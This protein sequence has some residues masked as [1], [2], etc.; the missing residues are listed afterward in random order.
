M[1]TVRHG[2]PA[3][4]GHL[5]A[6][7][8]A[9]LAWGCTAPHPLA[10][11]S[12]V[13][14]PA[15]RGT[16]TVEVVSV[17][18]EAGTQARLDGEVGKGHATGKGAATGAAT[19]A[20]AG[21]MVSLQTGPF[22][23][24]LAPILVPA[25]TLMGGAG[26]AVVG[27]AQGIP[28]KEAQAVKALLARDPADLSAE[29][30]RKVARRLP[31]AG[32]APAPPGSTPG[33]RLEVSAL[34]WGLYGGAGSYPVADFELTT[35]YRVLDP[36]GTA[37]LFRTFT[38][39]GPRRPFQEWSA[40]EG[41][42]LREA[43][44]ATLDAA[45]EAVADSAFLVQDFHLSMSTTP[46]TC[47][48]RPRKPGQVSLAASPLHGATPKVESLSPTLQWEAFP[49]RED[50]DHDSGRL[51]ARISEVR[52]DLR[53]WKSV[54]GGPGE[55][56]YERLGFR[57]D[58]QS[59]PATPGEDPQPPSAAFV[60]HRLDCVLAPATE[61]LWSVRARFRLDGEERASR[62]SMNQAPDSRTQPAFRRWLPYR[63]PPA[64]GLCVYDGIP[65]LRHHRFCTP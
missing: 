30:A 1:P 2:R 5:S 8:L 18:P 55:L 33:L 4:G 23:V 51:F 56:V 62:W 38:V 10:Y 61:Y 40:E 24:I 47:G 21:L 26:G 32:K 34:S 7:L 31:S 13:P 41:R 57:L 27:Y 15:R 16:T 29:L 64:R 19:G 59:D 14:E 54:G 45:A 42:R 11:T 36:Q 53:I 37:L 12:A 65:P 50:L 60:E 58:P 46:S 63:L 20:A 6:G 3:W 48:L 17:A 39:G 44:E 49:R 52:Y 43:L 28:E 9:V 22:F 25:G 35:S